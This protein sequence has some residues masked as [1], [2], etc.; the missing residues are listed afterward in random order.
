MEKIMM[1]LDASTALPIIGV[2]T[3]FACLFAIDFGIKLW[4]KMAKKSNALRTVLKVSSSNDMKR[5]SAAWVESEG[6]ASNFEE[7]YGNLLT[8]NPLVDALMKYFSVELVNGICA[9][10]ECMYIYKLV[11][12]TGTTFMLQLMSRPINLTDHKNR[13]N[14][15]SANHVLTEEDNIAWGCSVIRS[16]YIGPTHTDVLNLEEALASC[17]IEQIVHQDEREN[18]VSITRMMR[19]MGGYFLK[20][21]AQNIQA[22]T[23]NTLQNRYS[24][25]KFTFEGEEHDIPMNRAFPIMLQNIQQ[26]GNTA[27]FGPP[28]VGKSSLANIIYRELSRVGVAPII[29]TTSLIKEWKDSG[30]LSQAL[31]CVKSR[32]NDEHRIV[33]IVDEA[34]TLLKAS[35]DGIHTE[36]QTIMLQLLSGDLKE[37]FN[38]TTI[39][40]F[41]AKPEVLNP[42]IFRGGRIGLQCEL[43]PLVAV[44]ASKVADEIREMNPELVF[45]KKKFSKI[46]N[47]VNTFPDGTVYAQ[48]NEITLADIYTCFTQR[49]TRRLILEAIRAAAGQDVN[50]AKKSL[51]LIQGPIIEVPR[52]A[53]DEITTKVVAKKAGNVALPEKEVEVPAAVIQ[54]PVFSAKKN[55]KIDNFRKGK[56]NRR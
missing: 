54:P 18:T 53:L 24:P 2:L 16:A 14:F 48:T 43:R 26:G 25:V 41:N 44:T 4:L 52:T 50:I 39:L 19:G 32:Y 8:V 33:F 12:K 45:D 21:V 13:P 23:L 34:E 15:F 17:T 46:C 7:N 11:S 36:E 1:M 40:V 47:A 27:I 38:C 42:A 28:G 9:S 20:N 22:Y 5:L 37:S 49:D 31:D 30:A 35:P 10:G 56:K 51:P 55:P 3:M 6:S 29:L